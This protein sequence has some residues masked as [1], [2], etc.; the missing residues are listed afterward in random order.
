MEFKLLMEQLKLQLAQ[1]KKVFE[2]TGVKSD[3]MKKIEGLTND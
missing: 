3:L 1:D 2:E